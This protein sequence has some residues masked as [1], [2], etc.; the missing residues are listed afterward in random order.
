M[1]V[2]H[3]DHRVGQRGA[4]GGGVAG[5]R[6]DHHH[7]DPGPELGGAGGQPGLHRGAGPAVDL[8]QQGLIT[9]DVDEPGLPRIRAHPPDP[10][11]VMVPVG[12][13]PRPPEPGLVHAQHPRRLGLDQLD[14]AVHD[15]R[16][17]HRRPRHPVRRSDLGLV[18]PVLDR[19]RQRRP[20]PG[21]RAH[22]GRHLRDLLGER[23]PR[24]ASV[25]H[26]QRRLRHCT[27]ANSPPHGRS[28]GR[29][30]TQSLPD[31]DTDPTRRTPGRVR[32][33]G[34]QLHDLDPEPR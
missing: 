23:L 21:R 5:V 29:V 4:D 20:Q 7:L 2:V 17:L 11:V 24:T 25:R 14:R 16:A 12:Q 22:P 13:P 9:G 32:V 18:P 15:H 30:S 1:E 3:R 26:R 6:V 10:A 34:D 27:A 19:H 33:V 28:R 8:P 31:V